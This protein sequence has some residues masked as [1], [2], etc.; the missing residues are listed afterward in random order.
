MSTNMLSKLETR[1][2]ECVLLLVLTVLK[3]WFFTKWKIFF[4]RSKALSTG[5][6]PAR[7]FG[8]KML[9]FGHFSMCRGSTETDRDCVKTVIETPKTVF[10]HCFP[11]WLVMGTRLSLGPGRPIF[12]QKRPFS[13]IPGASARTA[14]RA[15]C[16]AKMVGT[17]LL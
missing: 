4:H 11:P 12:D 9:I 16:V 10:S 3:H 14:C 15:K 13:I 8:S 1:V 2:V 5:A 6:G 17:M 7:F